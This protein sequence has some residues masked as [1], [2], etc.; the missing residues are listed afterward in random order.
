M[1]QM[2]DV[3]KEYLTTQS[4]EKVEGN[5][6]G[7]AFPTTTEEVQALVRQA[8]AEGAAIIPV[9]GR[10]GLTS[11]TYPTNG[12]YLISSEKMDKIVKL[13]E[14]NSTLTIQAGVTLGAIIDYLE[15]TDYFYAPDPGSK[16][17]T[18]GGMAA[19]NAGGMTAIKYGVTRDN[20]VSFTV[21]LPNGEAIKV[22]TNNKKNASGYDLKNIF[23]GAEGTLGIM[24][25]VEILLRPRTAYEQSILIGFENL[26]DVTKMIVE[27]LNSNVLPKSLEVLEKDSIA[28]A[29]KFVG[30]K[31]PEVAGEAHLIMSLDGDNTDV[32]DAEIENLRALAQNTN[33]SGFLV[34]NEEDEKL[35]WNVRD[36]ILTA[37]ASSGVW[38]MYDPVV[39]NNRIADLINQAKASAKELNIV[40]AF[41]GHA[42]D[43]N[44]HICL[45]NDGQ[46][47]ADWDKL[48]D[49]FEERTYQL[50]SDL[51]GLP[52]AEHGIGLERR[53][54]MQVFF[55]DEYIGAMKAIK[56]AL[57]PKGI[58]N[59][60]KLFE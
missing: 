17:A 51:G 54:L 12:E 1:E 13:D 43:G 27:I 7:I 60:G 22:G 6:S 57:D 56:D 39:P 58:M 9:G 44:I 5:A 18:I 24:T 48:L 10:T 8:N 37:I 29:E 50:V 31:L 34:L 15:D 38:K 52:A 47:E 21:V 40:S 32:I 46:S 36:N 49:E 14:V 23:I 42:G 19:T 30:H 55:T 59:P 25:E 26:D 11:A 35:A 16:Q 4:Q 33:A 53:D 2:Q 28:T 20:I 41:F 3:S 45:L